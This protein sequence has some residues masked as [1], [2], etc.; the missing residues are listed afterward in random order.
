MSDF[1][2]ESHDLIA[3]DRVEGTAVYNRQGEHLGKIDNFM[4]EKRSGQVRY[5]VLSFGGFLGIG[6]DH[7]PLPW[8]ILTYDTDKGGYVIDLD[9]EV[10]DNA[11]RYAGDAR[12]D[13]DD[14]YGR[15]VYQYY[16]VVYPW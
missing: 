11:P 15:N 12:P 7:Y 10:L 9:K 8:S 4:V 13:Y 14:T 16:G 5:A 3:S 6:N 2:T 1:T